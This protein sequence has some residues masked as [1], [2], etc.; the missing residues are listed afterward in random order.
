MSFVLAGTMFNVI[1]AVNSLGCDAVYVVDVHKHFGKRVASIFCPEEAARSF[2]HN[3]GTYF[4]DYTAS[5]C[6]ALQ[7]YKT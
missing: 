2:S 3:F 1:T 5:Y 7:S 6:T 4:L